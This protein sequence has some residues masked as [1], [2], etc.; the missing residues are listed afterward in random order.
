MFIKINPMNDEIDGKEFLINL[1]QIKFI[2]K[3]GAYYALIFGETTPIFINDEEYKKITH[4]ING[5][6]PIIKEVQNGNN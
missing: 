6:C 1:D 5:D 2:I 3:H 4:Q